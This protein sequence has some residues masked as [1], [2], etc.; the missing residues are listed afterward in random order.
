MN[1]RKHLLATDLSS[2]SDRAPL[3]AQGAPNVQ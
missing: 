3:T 2:R 1:P